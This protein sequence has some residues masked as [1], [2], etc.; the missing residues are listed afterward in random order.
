MP[1]AK[2]M[3]IKPEHDSD[4][5]SRKPETPEDE[6]EDA[7]ITAQV[8]HSDKTVVAPTVDSSG[9]LEAAG[10]P[11]Y[12]DTYPE[13]G[14]GYGVLFACVLIGACTAGSVSAL[15]VYQAEYAERFPKKSSFQIN[16]I[17]G[18]MGFVSRSLQGPFIFLLIN[19]ARLVHGNRSSNL[20]TSL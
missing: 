20:W 9:E 7:T 10:A 12:D 5:A 3:M 13:G 1:S 17:G 4:L 16:L 15:G 6:D 19:R 8:D 11:L 2:D 18:F 14:Y